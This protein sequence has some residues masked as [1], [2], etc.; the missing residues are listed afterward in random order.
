MGFL[1]AAMAVE[2]VRVLILTKSL[3]IVKLP[4]HKMSHRLRRV[5]SY[6]QPFGFV[7]DSEQV[8]VVEWKGRRTGVRTGRRH[9]GRI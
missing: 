7:L 1:S 8:F 5:A 3:R 9:D 2:A 6:E 4:G